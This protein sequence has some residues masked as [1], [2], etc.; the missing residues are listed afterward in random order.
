MLVRLPTVHVTATGFS[1]GIVVCVL[2]YVGERNEFGA[3]DV[4]V[5]C[6]FMRFPHVN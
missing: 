5:F 6:P 2:G 3:F 4:A 1:F